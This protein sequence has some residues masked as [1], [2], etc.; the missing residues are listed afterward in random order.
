[1]EVNLVILYLVNIMKKYI[2][3]SLSVGILAGLS[4]I[5]CWRY[6]ISRAMLVARFQGHSGNLGQTWEALSFSQKLELINPWMVFITVGNIAQIFGC[7]LAFTDSDNVLSDHDII[8]GI[9]CFCSWIYILRYLPHDSNSYIIINTFRRSVTTIAPYITGVLPIFLAYVFLGMACFW[10]SGYYANTTDSMISAY[11]LM[12]G[13][14][15]YDAFYKVTRQHSVIGMLYMYSFILFFI[16]CVH[17]IFIAIIQEGFNSLQ[18]K[19]PKASDDID[20]DSDDS[21]R[22]SSSPSMRPR[23][24]LKQFERQQTRKK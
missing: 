5:D 17:N 9:S 21:P 8:I 14:S 7:M 24:S 4:L 11:S 15:I 3:L 1:V 16:C 19:P 18:T 2:W 6:L 10:Q 12:N 20:S 13:D 23:P 22:V